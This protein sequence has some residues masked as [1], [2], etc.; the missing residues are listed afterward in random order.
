MRA[1]IIGAALAAL[2][3]IPQPVAA[4]DW[5][6][7]SITMV[8]PFAAGG[9]VDA[10]GRVIAPALSERLGQQVVVEN[11]GGGGGIIGTDRV[12]KAAPDGYQIVLGSVSTHAQSQAVRKKPPYNVLTDFAP[13]AL[14]GEAPLVLVTRKTLAA[15]TVKEFT[16]HTKA[17]AA[18][19]QFGSAG[20]GSATHLAC[21]LLNSAIG[22]KTTH[23]P[24]RGGGPAMQDLIGG[25]L[26]YTCNVV[27]S[28]LSQIKGNLINAV[29]ILSRDRSP[30]L[31]DLASAHEQGLTGFD[32]T[33][34]NAILLP[35]GTPAAIVKKFQGAAQ[36][37]MKSP[38]VQ[39][40]AS[41][42]GVTIVAPE[43]RSSD[44][45]AKFLRDEIEK[46]G[47]TAKAAGIYRTM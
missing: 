39:K 11:V 18:K 31:P 27:S 9:Q 3:T 46:W 45:L 42:I 28:A 16:A 41:R 20:A 5:P 47:K 2:A 21:V 26:D 43:R 44:Y 4:Q 33:T 23:V 34:W 14:I 32:V 29:A 22:V 6:T 24:Y 8:V 35:A 19:M 38:E 17:N 40:R 15:K 12:A 30:V 10:L 25:R 37:A 36:A 1:R 13:V 7:R